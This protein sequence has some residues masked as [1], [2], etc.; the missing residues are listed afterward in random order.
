MR[1]LNRKV[2]II[3]GVR[4]PFV[5][6]FGKYLDATNQDL[7]TS[8][9]KELVQKYSL[10][11]KLLGDVALGA[12]L[13][14]SSDFNLAR[15]SV[16]DSGLDPRTPGVDLQRA[17]GTGLEA[18]AMIANKISTGQIDVGIGG[19][20]DSNSDLPITYSR[21]FTRK[22]LPMRTAKTLKQRLKILSALRPQDLKPQVPSVTEPRTGLSMGEHTELMAKEWKIS[23]SD[24]DQ[25][26]LNSQ[27]N[28]SKAYSEGFYG[29][30]VLPFNGMTRDEF[31][32]DSITLDALIK[33][34]PAFDK[35]N[36]TLT[37]GNST[38]LTD[39]AG[40]VL[41]SSE[42]YAK[43]NNLP[44]L[45]YFEDVQF[46][47]ADFL[48]DEGLLMAPTYAVS[49]LLTRN[50]LKLQDFDIYEIHEAFAAQVL[51]NMAAW[52]DEDYCKSR[53]GLESKL[54]EIPKERLNPKG[55]SLALGHPFAA[56]GARITA[57]L[58]KMLSQSEKENAIGLI[59][60]CTAGGMGVAGILSKKPL[61]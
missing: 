16:L 35:K 43:K 49:A 23:R 51:S 50:N 13:K 29:D 17:C 45:A 6:S 19:G 21:S 3:G 59:S 58:A 18:I 2:V 60:L 24:Q 41:L 12:V 9:L 48:N 53:L 40:I 22:V 42:D 10:T 33:L 8:L 36:G 34:K 27:K 26:A 31:I 37:A 32:R 30:L 38:P 56:T 11:G 55:G 46:S 15:E 28:A 47:A 25:L 61:S 39:G 14:K 44:I 57:A 7:L 5:K 4:T 54:G 52:N 1:N 20:S